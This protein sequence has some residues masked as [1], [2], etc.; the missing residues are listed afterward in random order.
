MA[1]Q[2]QP[3]TRFVFAI[4][5]PFLLPIFPAFR[6]SSPFPCDYGVV[7]CKWLWTLWLWPLCTWQPTGRC[8]ALV[9]VMVLASHTL[10]LVWVLVAVESMV[11]RTIRD[12]S[13]CKKYLSYRDQALLD[14]T[15]TVTTKIKTS[16]PTVSQLSLPFYRTFLLIHGIVLPLFV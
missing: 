9:C 4:S 3:L 11:V 1:W 6:A 7:R 12:C 8:M 13:V 10:R 2:K 5:V 15:A 14:V 16:P